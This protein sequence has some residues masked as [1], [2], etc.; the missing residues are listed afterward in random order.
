MVCL[1]VIFFYD[2]IAESEGNL[3]VKESCNALEPTLIMSSF[4]VFIWSPPLWFYTITSYVACFV[5]HLVFDH[6]S[7][8]P[9]WY[10]LL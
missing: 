1:F 7:I 10:L 5:V 8:H 4:R 9:F 6:F 3:V 2:E